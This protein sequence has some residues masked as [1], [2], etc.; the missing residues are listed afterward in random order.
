[1]LNP[2][3]YVKNLLTYT[4]PVSVRRWRSSDRKTDQPSRSGHPAG[5]HTGSQLLL[6]QSGPAGRQKTQPAGTERLPLRRDRPH[7]KLS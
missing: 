2:Y 6:R 3:V 4:V 7:R 1:M 5:Y